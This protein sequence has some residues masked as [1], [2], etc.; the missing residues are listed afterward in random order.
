MLLKIKWI[1]K[2]I[3]EKAL[4]VY[5]ATMKNLYT[6]GDHLLSS[7]HQPMILYRPQPSYVLLIHHGEP[8][9]LL[10][11][12]KSSIILKSKEGHVVTFRREGACLVIQS[13]GLEM[14]SKQ[15][16][17]C[18]SIQV[19]FYIDFPDDAESMGGLSFF[20]LYYPYYLTNGDLKIIS[21]LRI[22]GGH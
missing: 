12:I 22:L 6:L 19:I 2:Q 8:I 1:A 18:E 11:S 7:R 20:L 13:E 3:Q 10:E 16:Q 21:V 17:L 14:E 4:W 5:S 9:D 15:L